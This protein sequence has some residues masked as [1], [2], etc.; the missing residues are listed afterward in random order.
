MPP[1]QLKK[2]KFFDYSSV[3]NHPKLTEIG[4]NGE[5]SSFWAINSS[6]LPFFFVK[7]GNIYRPFF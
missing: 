1:I 4:K 2:Y 3:N 5:K 6:I 7:L